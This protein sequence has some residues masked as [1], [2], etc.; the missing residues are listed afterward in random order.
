MT[1]ELD[2]ETKQKQFWDNLEKNMKQTSEQFTQ[3]FN[4]LIQFKN[5]LSST[6][7]LKSLQFHA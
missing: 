4:Y 3:L 1:F 5:N 2:K 7:R 6:V